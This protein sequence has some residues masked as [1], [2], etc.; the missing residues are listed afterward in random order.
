MRSPN[1]PKPPTPKGTAIREARLAAGLTLYQLAD[2]TGIH[3]S[4]L[5]HYEHGDIPTSPTMV[6]RILEACR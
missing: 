5:C 3:A 4:N 1:F 2:R 6:A